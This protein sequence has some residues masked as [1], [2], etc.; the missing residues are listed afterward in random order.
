MLNTTKIIIGLGNEIKRSV[1]RELRR[2]D[3]GRLYLDYLNKKHFFGDWLELN[4]INCYISEKNR[5]ILVKPRGS[6][7]ENNGIIIKN[8]L[9]YFNIGNTR[10]L[11]VV[12]P[13]LYIPIGKYKYKLYAKIH[14]QLGSD[15]YNIL[16]S[17]L[18]NYLKDS[19]YT[20]LCLGI[21]NIHKEN[22]SVERNFIEPICEK[23]YKTYVEAFELADEYFNKKIINTNF[24]TTDKI[25]FKKKYPGMETQKRFKKSTARQR[26]ILDVYKH[27][28]K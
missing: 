27:I 23:E 4:N 6:I 16:N 18:M 14:N 17:S 19:N 20:R 7:F 15:F 8:I 26:Y 12:Y 24:I 25:Q 3:V 10:N 22:K 2:G 9:H 21:K 13:D 1:Q 11:C 5:I 28:H